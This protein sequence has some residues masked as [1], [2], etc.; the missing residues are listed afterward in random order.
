[1]P[2]DRPMRFVRVGLG[3]VGAAAVVLA[4][5]SF[6][7]DSAAPDDAG[8]DGGLA[9]VTAPPT[10]GSPTTDAGDAGAGEC[11]A[12]FP[13]SSCLLTGGCAINSIPTNGSAVAF[14]MSS[15]GDIFFTTETTVGDASI[16][17]HLGKI[18]AG[19]MSAQPLRDTGRQPEAITTDG[20]T[21][22]WA[23]RD[24]SD[25]FQIST[26][27]I[28][29]GCLTADNFANR[30]NAAR[31]EY[32][33]A[34]ASG[35]LFIADDDGVFRTVGPGYSLPPTAGY[36]GGAKGGEVSFVTDAD[37]VYWIYGNTTQGLISA[38]HAGDDVRQATMPT[39]PTLGDGG[40]TT[41]F[42][43]HGALA[44]D[45]TYVYVGIT[46]LSGPNAYLSRVHRLVKA[47]NVIETTPLLEVA[48]KGITS[49]AVDSKFLYV[50]RTDGLWLY[51]KQTPTAA[52][53]PLSAVGSPL[54]IQTN[55][56]VLAW[57]EGAT[58]RR[59]NK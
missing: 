22:Y 35:A 4:C 6:S 3:V 54:W 17:G 56:S 58:A 31:E 55:D 24:A 53:S 7:G 9:D 26:C 48:G 20:A 38:T 13:A 57:Q 50:G 23:S 25:Y 19:A 2:Y 37:R 11:E 16:L 5:S 10:D 1:L 29:S 39:A 44:S 27:S 28:A 43:R 33:I 46:Y 52:T 32:A 40:A 51:D 42:V 14:T 15:A 36:L 45:C 8:V 12:A 30:G 21:V 49:L 18:A 47:T 41:P 34:V 59:L